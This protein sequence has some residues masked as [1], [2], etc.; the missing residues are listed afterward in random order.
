ALLHCPGTRYH[1]SNA[2]VATAGFVLETVA[3][4]PFEDL[5]TERIFKPLGMSRS[6]F[7]LTAEVKAR[8]AIGNCWTYHGRTFPHPT[9]DYV[10]LAP[11]GG[12]FT[13]VLDMGRFIPALYPAA[14]S[15]GPFTP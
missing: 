7:R 1:Y 12:L 2:A 8:T 13:T 15:T 9:T 14:G 10:A 3:K 11:A 6:S 5:A 4:K